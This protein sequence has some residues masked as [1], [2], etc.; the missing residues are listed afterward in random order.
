MLSS[1]FSNSFLRRF[2]FYLTCY[3]QSSLCLLFAE[4]PIIV[5]VVDTT[6]VTLQ[7][8]SPLIPVGQLAVIKADTQLAG[9]ANLTA[10]VLCEYLHIFNNCSSLGNE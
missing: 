1:K 2:K 5:P 8:S 6:L 3:V 4:C 7:T 9:P 10:R